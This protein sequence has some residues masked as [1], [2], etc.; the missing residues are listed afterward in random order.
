MFGA[1]LASADT[2]A[3][4]EY[5]SRLRDARSLVASAR[6]APAAQR[7]G[8]LAQAGALLRRT[9]AIR[10]ADGSTIPIDDGALAARLTL[11][12]DG[13]LATTLADLDGRIA[14][15]DRASTSRLTAAAV[16]EQ[17]RAVLRAQPDPARND[18]SLLDIFFA[19]IGQALSFVGRG[20]FSA[21]DPYVVIAAVTGLGVGIALLVLGILG[22]GVR[23][24]IQDEAMSVDT[25]V[26]A[27]DDPT[28]HL[29]R[30]DAAIVAGRS[31]EALHELYLFALASLVSHETIRF[32]PALTDR[33]L[34]A[35]AAAIPQIG[36]LRAL[37]AL[38]ERVWFGLKP[39]GADEAVRAR[40]LA[41]RVAA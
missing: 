12:D 9:D 20:T 36:P 24:R 6:S 38:H 22:R 5:A 29:R 23:E 33:E 27:A 34:L 28:A 10:L 16:D 4:N 21:V 32:D 15:A 30:A 8:L 11:A 14:T 26:G 7:P 31:R 13:A 35:R 37:V 41:E 39:A 19:L 25:R 17:L 3:T 40:E 2:V 18:P 1:G